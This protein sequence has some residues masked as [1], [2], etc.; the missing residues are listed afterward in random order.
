MTH[1]Y[2]HVSSSRDSVG[3][4][5]NTV[6]KINHGNISFALK[7]CITLIAIAVKHNTVIIIVKYDT[8][9]PVR[10]FL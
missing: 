6:T 2:H 7:P 3:H 5:Q 4:L 8:Q 10:R 9:D 1:K